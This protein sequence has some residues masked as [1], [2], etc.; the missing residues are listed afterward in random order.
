MSEIKQTSEPVLEDAPI[1]PDPNR[2][3]GISVDPEA[4]PPQHPAPETPAEQASAPSAT[5]DDGILPDPNQDTG[6]AVQEKADAP[7]QAPAQKAFS[8]P[9]YFAPAKALP[10]DLMPRREAAIELPES[11]VTDI[12]NILQGAFYEQTGV[13]L[14]SQE[15]LRFE[16]A[17]RQASEQL[18]N[19]DAAIVEI[20]QVNHTYFFRSVVLRQTIISLQALRYEEVDEPQ[21]SV[22]DI[23]YLPISN[24]LIPDPARRRI[25]LAQSESEETEFWQLSLGHLPECA[26]PRDVLW[27]EDMNFLLTDSQSR[28]VMELG[29]DGEILWQFEQG[30]E[31]R[32]LRNPVK[33]TRY[34]TFEGQKRYLIVDQGHH[35]VLEVSQEQQLLWQYGSQGQSRDLE[36]YLN[37]PSDIQ[38]TPQK[39]YLIADSGNHRVLEIK[40]KQ[41]L[42]SY[43][44]AHGLDWPVY[45]ER[46]G[47]GHT[48][49]V[50]QLQHAVFEFDTQHNKVHHCH[51]Y[52]PGMDERFKT[53]KITKVLRRH[54]QNLLIVDQERILELDYLNQK[55]VW[56]A[57]LRH[58][59]NLLGKPYELSES[60]SP[61]AG[62][63]GKAFEKYEAAS[64]APEMIT[65]RQMLQ[66]VPLF[67]NAPAPG[68]FEQL[69]KV[70]K[71]RDFQ[72]GSLIVEKGKPLKS[73]F[74]IQT[75]SVEMLSEK[76][77]EAV[78][79]LKAGE[80]FG[81]MGIVFVEPRQSS[82]RA[83]TFCGLY[84][85][86]KKPFD[87]LV[88]HYPEIEAKI[89]KMASERLVIAKIKQGQTAEKT[90]ARFQEVLAMQKARFANAHAKSGD[91]PAPSVRPSTQ[92]GS[93]QLGSFR[94]HRPQYTEAEK[95]LIHEALAQG[96]QC[97][98]MH[99]FIHLTCRMKG[100]RAFLVMMVLEK[101]G[102]LLYSQPTLEDIQAEK[103]VNSEVIVTLAT[104]TPLEQLIEDASMIA[105]IDKVEAIPLE[106]EI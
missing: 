3:A 58:L 100:A 27:L 50:D 96:Q 54:N 78:I 71:F 47:N 104:H 20:E 34:Q 88:E 24:Y 36:G 83:K 6:V 55:I 33:A 8:L 60:Q 69:E 75:G 80:S 51:F 72:P 101:H 40:N 61:G 79:E 10:A 77:G 15:K 57:Q 103:P 42:H 91:T 94:A 17:A 85:L 52:R 105:E 74:F 16:N 65:L 37:L 18:Q 98:E 35:R 9:F 64:S 30:S 41:I 31:E 87:K 86:E 63:L 44:E 53:G 43:N 66:K 12:L 46:L 92:A 62:M 102:S 38:Y 5:E 81:L 48:L 1:M 19:S 49:I 84:E 25:L 22:K 82:I 13:E 7:S 21:G 56:L 45:A 14:N 89:S 70:L 32:S 68:F 99:V 97:Y 2:D 76:E 4:S 59:Q 93:T 28:Q 95:H 39:T 26:N 29:L 90:Q 11:A 23:S 106:A 67:E 73:M